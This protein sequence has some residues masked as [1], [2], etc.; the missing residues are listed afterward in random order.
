MQELTWQDVLP[1]N[2][3]GRFWMLSSTSYALVVLGACGLTTFRRAKPSITTFISGARAGLGHT[4]TQ[5]YGLNFG[6]PKMGV[7][8]P[9]HGLKPKSVPVLKSVL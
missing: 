9:T 3:C 6:D 4:S 7:V 5:L 8:H 2:S 1:V